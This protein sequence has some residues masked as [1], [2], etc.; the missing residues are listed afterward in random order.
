[1][2]GGLKI[3]EDHKVE[4]IRSFKFTNI[5]CTDWSGYSFCSLIR[6]YIQVL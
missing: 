5:A 3:L 1:M 2:E 6:F 4:E